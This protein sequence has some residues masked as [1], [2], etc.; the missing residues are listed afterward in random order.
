[1]TADHRDL[2]RVYLF[3]SLEAARGDRLLRPEAWPRRK[4]AALLARLA[5][6]RRLHKEQAIDFLWPESS[7]QAG[8]NNLYRTLHA[9]R[10]TLD[11]SLGPKTAGATFSFND[12]VL[13]LDESVWVDVAVFERLSSP[14]PGEPI[15]QQISRLEEALA[16]YR[17]NFLADEPYAEWALA[18]RERLIRQQRD[19]RLALA[20][21]YAAGNRYAQAAAL[22][23]PLLS[24]D[25]ADEQ[26]HR[27]LM[28]LYALMGQRSEALR[29]YQLCAEALA[30]ELGVEPAAE[31]VALYEQIRDGEL[32]P[33]GIPGSPLL[34]PAASRTL[35]TTPPA[36]GSDKPRPLFVGR[37][38][39]LSRLQAHLEEVMAGRGGILFLT[40]EAGQGKTT[41]MTEFAYRAM[42]DHPQLVAAAG[43]CQAL[44]G[45]G[46]P[47]L[48]FRDLIAM[49]AGDWQRPWLGGDI[50]SAHVRRLQAIA[51]QTARA[52]AGY[53]PD[54]VNTIVPAAL[55]PQRA[56]SGSPLLGQPQIF[57][58]MRQLLRELA[59]HQPLLLLL[60]DFQWADSA[61]T[62]LLFYLGRQLVNSPILM[63]AAYRPSE[64]SHTPGAA[65]PLATVVQELVR[66]RG[67]IQIDLGA[68]IPA[69]RRYFVDA[70]LDSEPNRLDASFRE[71]LFQRT[72]GHPLFTV[73]LLRALQE[74]GDL[75]QDEAGRWA[76]VPDLNWGILPARVEA[77]IT[78]R[79][80]RLPKEL[81]QHLAVASVEGE[82]FTVE[83]I[84]EL[85]ALAVR[86]LL[87]QLSQELDRRHRLVRE[88]GEVVLGGRRLTRYQFRH[89][90]FQQYLYAQLG[91]AERGQL[92]RE[93]AAALERIGGDDLDS[94]AVTL[95][96][97]YLAAGETARAV[98]HLERAGD[99]A[100]R[101]V[102]LEEAI[103]FY[104]SALT[105]WT[106]GEPDAQAA[107]L[108]K[109][110]MALL[111]L[112][113][114]VE[115]IDALS[116][117]HRLYVQAGNRIGMGAMQRLIARSYF[118]QGDRA[119][120]LDHYHQALSLLEGAPPSGG[121][122]SAELARVFGGLAQM[123]MT[124]NEYDDAVN[125]GERALSLA[126]AADREDVIV[127]AL[128]TVG[129][130][131]ANK[132]EAERG[133]SMVARS[134]QR[135]E[136]L[137]LP[138]DAGRAY[139]GWTDALVTLERYEEARAVLQR[140]LAYARKVK[141]R[142]FEGVALVQLG[143]LDW[144]A[145]RWRQAWERRQEIREWM[146]TFPGS[147]FAKVW[148]SNFLG[149]IYNDVGQPDRARELLSGYT[150]VA[151]RA[152]EPQTTVPH[153]G[154]LARCAPSEAQAAALVREILALTEGAAYP[155]YEIMPAL[156][157]AC[158]WLAQSSGGGP[159]A[160]GPL[161]KVH[162]Q[163]PNR[164]SAASL[165][166][167]RAMAAGA[168]GEWEEAAS[169]YEAAAATWEALQRPLDQLRALSG[170]ASALVGA[171]QPAA[172]DAV[173]ER[174][175]LPIDALAGELDDR[176]VRDSF[177]M[178]PLVRRLRP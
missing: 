77:V 152:H 46:D 173:R 41:L 109:L 115:A 13:R 161:E 40:G 84:A 127:H 103:Q 123:H 21:H 87:H 72:R 154:Q 105:H 118:E 30:A 22:L 8:A 17:G 151:R 4:A 116:K 12:G 64:V 136:A 171:G 112:G 166:E 120:A 35:A 178:T 153:L 111:A 135:A 102:A 130:S 79:V 1:M 89:N 143:Y 15:Q 131:L 170:L 34:E 168:R 24:R 125:W 28:R 66:Y 93:I 39:E 51:P 139:A 75:A 134:Q 167:V 133:L 124:A 48:P 114:A 47:Y 86:P 97:H 106:G 158:G 163:M 69:E 37:E 81:R 16:Y 107:L 56:G 19:L 174:A 11:T 129:V 67:E 146:N 176:A 92:H 94:L 57:D 50:S 96:Y 55:L 177:L 169:S 29:Q 3:G 101:R 117:A 74:Q 54:L 80:E 91:A 27:A 162:A 42:R 157:F 138:H 137:G 78:R 164:Q 23:H 100:R 25:P 60:D 126:R 43:A 70:L 150:A 142:M 121:P 18:P 108:H 144:W 140:M 10:Q 128:T 31:T 83:V 175:R 36:L 141:A 49:L 7:L 104:R 160:L 165:C 33:P 149:L 44:A 85:L 73:E 113:N 63:I 95:A 132:G 26:V 159:A 76:A 156:T 5:Y 38:R 52:I 155:A 9:L 62:N 6:E 110:G 98:P 45:M 88:Q 61:S 2:I 119:E 71:A 68:F 59:L 99:E 148:A 20:A 147:S 53:A 58:Q 90:L 82:S 65:P 14:L 172:L 122:E 145:G 32:R